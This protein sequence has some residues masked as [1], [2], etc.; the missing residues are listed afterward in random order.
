MQ[1]LLEFSTMKL[2]KEGM[3]IVFLLNSCATLDSMIGFPRIYL[4]NAIETDFSPPRTYWML[5]SDAHCVKR[6]LI[7]NFTS[8]KKEGGSIEHNLTCS[9]VER[10]FC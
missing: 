5:S 2:M 10:M 3:L 1:S 6:F 9:S 4:E 8:V 7:I